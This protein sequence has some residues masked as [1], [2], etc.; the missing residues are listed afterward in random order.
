MVRL[1][2]LERTTSSVSVVTNVVTLSVEGT[3]IPLEVV[4]DRPI[5]GAV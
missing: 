3:A 2:V 5:W 4:G 1:P